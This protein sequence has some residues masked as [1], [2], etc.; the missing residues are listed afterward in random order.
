MI[1][2]VSKECK[3]TVS[4][5]INNNTSYHSLNAYCVG[6]LAKFFKYLSLTSHKNTLMRVLFSFYGRGNRLWEVKHLVQGHSCGEGRMQTWVSQIPNAVLWHFS[7]LPLCGNFR[8]A[9][10]PSKCYNSHVYHSLCISV[11]GIDENIYFQDYTKCLYSQRPERAQQ[12]RQEGR[13]TMNISLWWECRWFIF[14][15]FAC[16]YFLNQLPVLKN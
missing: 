7:G 16:P 5:L 11:G 15:S 12:Q 8:L 6:Q 3:I 9:S 1:C 2:K 14:F 10:T 4:I 13:P